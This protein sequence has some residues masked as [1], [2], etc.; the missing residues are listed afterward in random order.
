MRITPIASKPWQSLAIDFYGPIPP[1]GNYQLVVSDIYSKFPGVE[2]VKTTSARACMPKLDHIIATYGI[3]IKIK[4]DNRPPFDG[5]VFKRYNGKWEA[6][7]W[8]TSTLL[9]PQ[10]NGNV[11]SV[12]KPIGKVMKTAMVQGINGGKSGKDFC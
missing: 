10:G 12:M 4:T 8:K 7:K 9:W 2:T 6:V 5:Q 11:E 3:P 1:C